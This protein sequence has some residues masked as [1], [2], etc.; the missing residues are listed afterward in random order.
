MDQ[1]DRHLLF[2]LLALQNGFVD[3]TQL[4]SAFGIWIEDKSRS[5][6]QILV[7][8]K[9]LSPQLRDLLNRLVDQHVQKRNQDVQASLGALSSS[10]DIKSF[11]EKLKDP[12]LDKSLAYLHESLDPYATVTHGQMSSMGHRFE[13]RRPLGRGGL[14]VVSI[15]HDRELNREVALKEIR[16]D[17]S[18]NELMRRRFV[19]EAEITGNL[20]HPG[21]VPVYG[22]G[23]QEDGRPYYA[24]RFIEG[25]NLGVH[26]KRFHERVKNGA[27]SF[28]GA[29]LKGLLRRFL[30]VC[31]AIGYAHSRGVLHRDLKPGNIMLGRF[32][33][34]LVVDWG[35]AKTNGT[36]EKSTDRNLE[37]ITASKL[38]DSDATVAGT[39]L[40]TPA[41]APP[42]QV[43]GQ[44][45]KINE[46]S[47]VYGLG[48]ILYETLCNVPPVTGANLE[49]ILS[50]I[51][52]GQVIP[53][54]RKVTAVPVALSNICMKALA[55]SQTDRY[56]STSALMKDVE[57]WLD[58]LPV[59][60]H[61]DGISARMG[62]WMRRNK[63][64]ARASIAGLLAVAILSVL[65]GSIAEQLRA[66]AIAAKSHAVEQSKIATN[67]AQNAFRE[68][69]R[70][71][72]HFLKAREAV[73]RFLTNVSEDQQLA[74]PGFQ[75]LRRKLLDDARS[76]YQNFSQ[77]N[78]N[79][80]GLQRETA[81]AN[82]RVASICSALGQYAEGLVAAEIASKQL[83]S[84]LQSN[85]ETPIQLDW[86]ECDLLRASLLL[87][88]G[89]PDQ[90]TKIA[91]DTNLF[92]KSLRIPPNES[93]RRKLV[94]A[95]SYDLLA[96]LA[97][98]RTDREASEFA[99]VESIQLREQVAAENP[100][101]QLML[102]I[103]NTRLIGVA[104]LAEQRHFSE[105]IDA[106]QGIL[107]NLNAMQDENEYNAILEKK[108]EVIHFLAVVYSG[109]GDMKASLGN[110]ET[111][112]RLREELVARNSVVNYQT[113]LAKS[114]AELSLM[115]GKTDQKENAFVASE[116]SLQLSESI[117]KYHPQTAEYQLQLADSLYKSCRYAK[118]DQLVERLKRSR[119]ILQ[120]LV[121]QK[122]VRN[123]ARLLLG[124][125]CDGMAKAFLDAKDMNAAL[126]SLQEARSIKKKLSEEFP[127]E[128]QY[129]RALAVSDF[130]LGGFLLESGDAVK[131]A[132]SLDDAAVIYRD[133]L[134]LNANDDDTRLQFVGCLIN[135][136]KANSVQQKFARGFELAEESFNELSR[137]KPNTNPSNVL[138]LRVGVLDLQSELY[139]GI[140]ELSRSAEAANERKKLKPQDMVVA[141]SVA[142]A[143][144]VIAGSISNE[145][146]AKADDRE[147][148]LGLA[149][150]ELL[151]LKSLGFSDS[152]KINNA[153]E[154]SILKDDPR[155]LEFVRSIEQK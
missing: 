141:L 111:V 116:R 5:L 62:R 155:F 102:D 39:I 81:E 90:A 49:E 107:K 15:A 143:F 3:R 108:A 24:M 109:H 30:D 103:A 61:P 13:F 129:R 88:F 2:G 145:D 25:D 94:L 11:L 32:G 51:Q 54:E 55:L 151:R 125:V 135:L 70:A 52:S 119:S 72:E 41:Y 10:D 43:S 76:Y 1:A 83:K 96:T 68:K 124:N 65:Y 85:S 154:L 140:G 117:A 126:E 31:D 69:R 7:D 101:V 148:Y 142:K 91:K 99:I 115:L 67:E 8:F 45:S 100:T 38:F 106:Y 134:E 36:S 87:E 9:A 44:L 46:R 118:P 74:A 42:E 48:A 73:D 136:G 95:K 16:E 20:E 66:S 144:A 80:L 26:I 34:T 33:E 149:I 56:E 47:D 146:V 79:E 138:S 82:R 112:V 121:D 71:D 123:G 50:K 77:N 97:N 22:L 53:P 131:A 128:F 130:K 37:S 104:Q 92:L 150:D 120:P 75:P 40:G 29:E 152:L 14:G 105:A 84:I 137:L 133:L 78:A 19:V 58:D 18:H 21:I 4:V 17:Q 28:N 153:K 110:Y 114:L 6:D 122:S 113:D 93:N 12:V 64:A 139:L 63:G 60:A 59:I 27:E 23:V 98:S 147:K 57:A 35:L 132:A 127:V 86:A 89:K